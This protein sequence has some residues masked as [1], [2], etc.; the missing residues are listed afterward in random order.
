MLE[1]G[2]RRH[3][4]RAP[5]GESADLLPVA[6][7][8]VAIAFEAA[9]VAAL[10]QG[11]RRMRRLGQRLVDV[12]AGRVEPVERAIGRGAIDQRVDPVRVALQHPVEIGDG[13]VEIAGGG[14]R[15]GAVDQQFRVAGREGDRRIRCGVGPHRVAGEQPGLPFLVENV[16]AQ[17]RRRLGHRLGQ[18]LQPGR[19]LLVF[20]S[21]ISATAAQ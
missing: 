3:V 18:G 5:G 21:A 20:P 11:R 6:A 12:G 4:L 1:I 15:L 10:E 19:P 14:G 2:P 17:A 13:A 16:G 8:A 7:R 9:D